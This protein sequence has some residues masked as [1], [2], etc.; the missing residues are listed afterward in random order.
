MCAF[1]K[2]ESEQPP[3]P[4]HTASHVSARELASFHTSR[5]GVDVLVAVA[6]AVEDIVEERVEVAEAVKVELDDG[7]TRSYLV[8]QLNVN[9]DTGPYA[10]M[11]SFINDVTSAIISGSDTT[12][13]TV[14]GSNG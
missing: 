13:V 3:K 9:E 2:L 8:N 6:E 14:D 5:F 10:D 7:D 11:L 12:D 1:A 4:A